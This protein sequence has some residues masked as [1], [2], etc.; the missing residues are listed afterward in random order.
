VS[1]QGIDANPKKVEV[2]EQLQLPQTWREIQKLADMMTIFSRFISKSGER[3]MPF[4][5]LLRKVYGFQGDDHAIAAFI[6]LKQYLR[7]LPTLVPPKFDDVPL[8]YV[9]ATDVFVNIVIAV[10]RPEQHRSKTTIGIL[11][12]WNFERHLDKI[13]TG[14][15]ATLCST[16]DDQE[17]EAL[18]SGSFHASHIESADGACHPKQRSNGMD[19]TVGHGDWPVW[20]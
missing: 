18:F 9:S 20:C 3:G 13:P 7:S 12:Q 16:H 19:S 11:C 17:A 15:E 1:A 8:L 4:Y 6:E 14:T 5:K 2:I 10:E